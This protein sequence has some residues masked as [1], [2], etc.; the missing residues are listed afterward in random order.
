M[1][2]KI[3]V[4][5]KYAQFRVM[6]GAVVVYQ[7]F[8][9][10]SI[11]DPDLTGVGHQPMAHDQW[12]NL[13]LR[14]RVLGSRIKLTAINELADPTA[15]QIWPSNDSTIPTN[16]TDGL[17]QPRSVAGLLGGATGSDRKTLSAS[18]TTTTIKG[19]RKLADDQGMEANFGAN[20]AIQWFWT[21]GVNQLN[22][23]GASVE[24]MFEIE[25]DV[26]IYDRIELGQS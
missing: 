13:Y 10:N 14:Y 24:C 3:R 8:R 23:G 18:M 26:D 9:G 21:V 12:G 17:E 15:I 25:Y 6:S 5:M 7:V 22:G 16:F 20:P 2:A 11:F 19:S 4:T 1:P